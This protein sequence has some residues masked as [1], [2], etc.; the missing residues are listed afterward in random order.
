MGT[1][2]LRVKKKTYTDKTK[3]HPAARH[4]PD[5]V[6]VGHCGVSAVKNDINTVQFLAE[7]DHLGFN[8]VLS[9][10]LFFFFFTLFSFY[11]TERQRLMRL[12]FLPL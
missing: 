6:T 2:A 7:A 9:V 8:L 11:I 3:L 1:R 12:R 5:I 4:A 10:C